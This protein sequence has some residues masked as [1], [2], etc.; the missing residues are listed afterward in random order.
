MSWDCKRVR[1]AEQVQDTDDSKQ[2]NRKVKR[3]GVETRWPEGT[4]RIRTW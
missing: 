2:T 1:P 3:K 4:W